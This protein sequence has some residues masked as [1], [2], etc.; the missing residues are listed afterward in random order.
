[1]NVQ[2]FDGIVKPLANVF[3]LLLGWVHFLGSTQTFLGISLCLGLSFDH[4]E[5]LHLLIIRVKCRNKKMVSINFTLA[6]GQTGT[7]SF[8]E[9]S[10]FNEGTF[11]FDFSR[12]DPRFDLVSQSLELLNLLLEICFIL[13]FLVTVGCIVNFLPDIFK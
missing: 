4:L 7:Y 12:L 11:V 9:L 10:V 13:L 6:L 3:F 5:S 8:N 2:I 1:M